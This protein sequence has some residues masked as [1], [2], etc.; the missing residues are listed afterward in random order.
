MKSTCFGLFIVAAIVSGTC[1]FVVV[2]TKLDPTAGT[3][4][5]SEQFH[6]VKK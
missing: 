2:R 3:N 1:L 5:A 4:D 6:D